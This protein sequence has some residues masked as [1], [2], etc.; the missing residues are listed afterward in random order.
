MGQN[1]GSQHHIFMPLST[2]PVP[3]GGLLFL[4]TLCPKVSEAPG[5]GHSAVTD[6][7]VWLG[8]GQVN[9]L[10]HF[11][12]GYHISQPESPY[13]LGG[14]VLLASRGIRRHCA[15]QLGGD[16]GVPIGVCLAFSSFPIFQ[17]YPCLQL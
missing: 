1:L 14:T 8:R 12:K 16:L 2:V 13:L 17:V 7:S 9:P 15:W 5:L 10:T 3:I 4:N 11:R 6:C